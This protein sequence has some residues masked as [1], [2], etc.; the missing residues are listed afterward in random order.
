MSEKN[1]VSLLAVLEAFAFEP[2][3][4]GDE[5]VIDALASTGAS[6]KKRMDA[7]WSA[8]MGGML[9]DGGVWLV[10]GQSYSF[11]TDLGLETLEKLR[12]YERTRVTGKVARD[13]LADIEREMAGDA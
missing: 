12:F 1:V 11:L 10:D 6:V 13:I 5:G 8:Y 3:T 4:P 2:P 7:M 9:N